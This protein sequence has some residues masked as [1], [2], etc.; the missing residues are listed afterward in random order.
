MVNIKRET[1]KLKDGDNVVI[2]LKPGLATTGTASINLYSMK[3]GQKEIEEVILEEG[4]RE[5][6]LSNAGINN[7]SNGFINGY[8]KLF[9]LPG[10]EEVLLNVEIIIND[11]VAA[12]V[13]IEEKL[14]KFMIKIT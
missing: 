10:K 6:N 4:E 13:K 14:F 7:I 1:I 8:G 9:P 11:R 12:S 5:I 3:I 2:A